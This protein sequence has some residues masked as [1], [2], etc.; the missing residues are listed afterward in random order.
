MI[1][2]K[3][4]SE[5]IKNSLPELSAQCNKA[6][7]RN[8]YD[9]AKQMLRYTQA[10]LAKNNMAMVKKCLRLACSLYE[11]GNQTV[12]NAIDNVYVF[13]FSHAILNSSKR[14]EEVIQAMPPVL[15]NLYA[16]QVI[17]SHI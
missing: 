10:Q 15:Y 14:H 9:F 16:R 3:Q 7:C 17:Y 6:A 13:S 11:K 8:P 5:Y 12:R 1:S 2:Q 4:L